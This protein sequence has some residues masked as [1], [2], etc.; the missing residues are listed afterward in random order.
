MFD[1]CFYAFSASLYIQEQM[2]KFPLRINIIVITINL[3]SLN[4]WNKTA[5]WKFVELKFYLGIDS[6]I[7]LKDK[8]FKS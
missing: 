3:F 8:G 5:L 7:I 2:F 1:K 6:Y 4:Y